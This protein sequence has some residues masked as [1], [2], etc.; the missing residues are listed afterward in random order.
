MHRFQYLPQQLARNPQKAA[1]NHARLA[2]EVDVGSPL[3]GL[4]RAVVAD[5]RQRAGA[6]RIR[7]QPVMPKAE[8]KSAVKFTRMCKFWKTNECKMGA[9]CTF[10]H[11]ATQLRPSPKPCFDFVKNGYCSRGQACRFV[12]EVVEMTTTDKFVE[13]Q[14]CQVGSQRAEAVAATSSSYAM[15][16]VSSNMTFAQMAEAGRLAQASQVDHQINQI[17]CKPMGELC[18]LSRLPHLVLMY[19][20]TVELFCPR[21]VV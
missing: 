20:K 12:H 17:L 9:D 5:T 13:V 1:P 2:L 10:A 8:P 19:M 16:A 21:S 3:F 14:H 7:L 4:A 6:R 18:K 15:P 11:S